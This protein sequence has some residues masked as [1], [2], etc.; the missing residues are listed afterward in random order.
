MNS[1][2]NFR[3]KILKEDLYYLNAEKY[4]EKI[5][6]KSNIIIWGCASTGQ[7]VYDFLEEF[8][9]IDNIKY[10][11]DNNKKKWGTRK[12]GLLVL[13][14][15]EVVEKVKEN[16]NTYIIVAALHLSD[17]RKQLLSLGIQDS[18]IDVNG[19]SLAKD[20]LTFKDESAYKIINSHIDEYEKVYSYLADERSRT[21]YLSILNC[22]ISLDNKYMMGIA[23]PAKDQYFDKEIINL[24]EN[25]VFCDCGS[26]NGDTLET[27]VTLSAGEYKKYIAIEADKDIFIELNK[28]VAEKG[29]RNVQT[30]NVACWNEKTILKFQ[31]AQSAGHVSEIGSITVQ[32]DTLDHILKGENVTFLKMD[33]EGA[34]EMALK[35]A[36]TLIQENKPVLAVCIYH[37]LQDYYKLP[38]IMKDLNQDYML[39]IRN[40]TDMVDTETVCYAV[41]KGR[42][43]CKS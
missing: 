35:G 30:H 14:P 3:K 8:G 21:V 32:A 18:V 12:N 9:S 17:I 31:S 33:I 37:S 41:P 28:K 6:E 5:K 40:Y 39:F 42:L 20:Y 4:A 36:A 10:F 25:E 38:L 23:T 7:S 11:A 43:V 13:S 26:F 24:H 16:S 19:F 34:E 27:F 29:Y 2:N 22:K 1:A 15:E